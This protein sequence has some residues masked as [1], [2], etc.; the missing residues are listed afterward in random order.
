MNMR[1]KG[2]V[3]PS[4]IDGISI[5]KNRDGQIMK[6]KLGEKGQMPIFMEKPKFQKITMIKNKLGEIQKERKSLIPII[7]K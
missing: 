6:M 1:R 5:I 3:M 7:K 4:K 2:L